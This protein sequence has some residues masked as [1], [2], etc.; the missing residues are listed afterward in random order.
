M[1]AGMVGITAC[2][3]PGEPAEDKTSAT[4]VGATEQ[5]TA[6]EKNT[7]GAKAAEQPGLEGSAKE[8]E[9]FSE[10]EAFSTSLTICR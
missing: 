4:A 3:V 7:D 2:N 1:V 6:V 9:F 10:A 5:A 8:A